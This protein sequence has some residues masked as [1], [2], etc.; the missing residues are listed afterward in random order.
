MVIAFIINWNIIFLLG[1]FFT[2]SAILVVCGLLGTAS[3][4]LAHDNNSN[5]SNNIKKKKKKYIPELDQN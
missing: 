3:C 2:F 5:K 1:F 4:N